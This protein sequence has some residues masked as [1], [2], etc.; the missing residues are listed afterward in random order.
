MDGWMDARDVSSVSFRLPEVFFLPLYHLVTDLC[1]IVR[2]R[3]KV[4]KF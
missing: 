4:E 2:Y 3:I 1:D